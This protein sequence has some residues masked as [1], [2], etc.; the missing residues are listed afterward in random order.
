MTGFELG[1]GSA[2]LA[3]QTIR[4]ARQL[5]TS[6]IIIVAQAFIAAVVAVGRKAGRIPSRMMAKLRLH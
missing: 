4:E 3:Q 6:A 5:Q 1:W 2:Q